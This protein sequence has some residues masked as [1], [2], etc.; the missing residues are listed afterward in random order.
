MK[1]MGKIKNREVLILIDYGA[2]HNFLAQALVAELHILVA[3]TANYGIMV[4]IE[5][6]IR[7]KGKCG[8]VALSVQGL[9]IVADFLPLELGNV[10]VILGMP[11]LRIDD[12]ITVN[13]CQLIM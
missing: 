6:S 9:I 1:L 5:N 2:T 7:S 3:Q 8:Q 11:W 13:W 4:G 10:D 12:E